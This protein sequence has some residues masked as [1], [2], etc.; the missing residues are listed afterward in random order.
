MTKY[1]SLIIIASVSAPYSGD[2]GFLLYFIIYFVT[3][4]AVSMVYKQS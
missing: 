4:V 1:S 3:I 2:N